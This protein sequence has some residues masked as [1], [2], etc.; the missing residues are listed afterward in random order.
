MEKLEKNLRSK[1]A[2]LESKIDLMESELTYLDTMLKQCGFASGI[3][4]LK[5]TVKE[6]ISEML[7]D[8]GSAPQSA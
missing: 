4:T 1:I 7:G 5:Y 6:L 8:N 2:M 3:A